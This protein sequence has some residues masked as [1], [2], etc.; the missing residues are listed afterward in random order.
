MLAGW[1]FNLNKNF[2][3]SDMSVNQ[4]VDVINPAVQPGLTRFLERMEAACN[5]EVSLPRHCEPR[6]NMAQDPGDGEQ[7]REHRKGL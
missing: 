4:R 3:F 1:A 2:V 5:G 7:G 6:Q